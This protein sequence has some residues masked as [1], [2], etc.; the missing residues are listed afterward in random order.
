MTSIK[1]TLLSKKD[2]H[3]CD[4]AKKLFQNLQ[5]DYPIALEIVDMTSERGMTIGKD[6][7]I[8]FPPGILINN[9]PFSYG[10]PSEKKIK[11]ELNRLLNS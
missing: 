6:F 8:F 9:K 5:A 1:V 4:V 3:H 10:R 2:C 7:G 11:K